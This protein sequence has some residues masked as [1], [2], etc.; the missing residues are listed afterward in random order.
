MIRLV[1]PICLPSRGG[2][3]V[4]LDDEEGDGS[5]WT[6]CPSDIPFDALPAD[7]GSAAKDSSPIVGR[8]SSSKPLGIC[9]AGSSSVV[10]RVSDGDEVNGFRPGYGEGG[11][12][13]S[14][15][16]TYLSKNERSTTI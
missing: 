16:S 4:S 5:E 10:G 12:T 9:T 11:L 15:Y 14:R 3:E 8:V 13:F 2:R 1:N 7:C 6:I